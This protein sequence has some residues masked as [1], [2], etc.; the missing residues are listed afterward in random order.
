MPEHLR[1]LVIILSLAS[2]VFL[3]VEKACLQIV[4]SEDFKRWRNLWFA[5]TLA[6]FL[7]YDFW[8]Y[9]LS[10]SLLVTLWSIRSK[11]RTALFYLLLFIIPIANA[12]IS[13]FG[14]VNYT[15][16]LN[17]SRLLALLLLLPC[18]LSTGKSSSGIG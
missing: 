14:V 2:A 18:L 16:Q 1:A 13:G 6:A 15:I 12:S 8:I 9:A 5:L 7:S 3:V 10:A 4:P 17:Q 11:N